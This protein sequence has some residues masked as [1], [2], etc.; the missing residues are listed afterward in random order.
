MVFVVARPSNSCCALF[1]SAVLYLYPWASIVHSVSRHK[2]WSEYLSPIVCLTLTARNELEEKKRALFKTI[3]V[4]AVS[5]TN[6][7]E[8]VGEELKSRW[9][10]SSQSVVGFS[11]GSLSNLPVQLLLQRSFSKSRNDDDLWESRRR[12][13]ES[14]EEELEEEEEELEVPIF[15]R[16][17]FFLICRFQ[18][19]VLYSRTAWPFKTHPPTEKM[20]KS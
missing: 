15:P 20:G 11:K 13:R 19:S 14:R 1:R 16:I 18:A 7:V 5:A 8:I 12:I 17:R 2:L 6:M 3:V 9:D 10:E 4:K